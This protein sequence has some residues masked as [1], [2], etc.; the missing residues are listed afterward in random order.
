[1]LFSYSYSVFF[2]K[3]VNCS[4]ARSLLKFSEC[5]VVPAYSI[6]RL[7]SYTEAQ[8]PSSAIH[9]CKKACEASGGTKIQIETFFEY[10]ASNYLWKAN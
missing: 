4:L 8:A 1:M 3:P 9:I 2:A 10:S 7:S 6:S 5:S